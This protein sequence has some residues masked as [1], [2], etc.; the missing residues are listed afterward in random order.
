MLLLLKAGDLNRNNLFDKNHICTIRFYVKLITEPRREGTLLEHW[1]MR[2]GNRPKIFT[3]PQQQQAVCNRIIIHRCY[4]L[5]ISWVLRRSRACWTTRTA[6]GRASSATQSSALSRTWYNHKLFHISQRNVNSETL[7]SK[8]AYYSTMF[9]YTR[10][11]NTVWKIFVNCDGN[12]IGECRRSIKLMRLT[13]LLSRQDFCFIS[14]RHGLA[15]S[16]R[17]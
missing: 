15:L 10:V 2:L 13:F 5:S 8:T 4:W 14:A 17:I 3:I 11:E 9:P 16:R 6:R 7:W 1:W 12:W